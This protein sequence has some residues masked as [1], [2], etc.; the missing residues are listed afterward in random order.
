MRRSSG[1]LLQAD[2]RI[3]GKICAFRDCHFRTSSSASR[4]SR[5]SLA[6]LAGSARHRP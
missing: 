4:P 5:S 2:I 3:A 6:E 1:I